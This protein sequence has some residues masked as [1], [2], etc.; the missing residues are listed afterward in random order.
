MPETDKMT[1]LSPTEPLF[2]ARI[3]I[4]TKQDYPL[5]KIEKLLRKQYRARTNITSPYTLEARF[6]TRHSPEE[7]R[8]LLNKI[9]EL[10]KNLGDKIT[11][12]CIESY[13]VLKNMPLP[14]KLLEKIIK[15][16]RINEREI[17]LVKS[18]SV[19][20]YIYHN[21]SKRTISIRPLKNLIITNIDLLQL[22]KT[23]YIYCNGELHNIMDI[24]KNF[25]TETS[26][27]L[28]Q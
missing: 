5:T 9:I 17:I 12:F 21:T 3:T 14:Q 6:I 8:K 20:M 23:S 10:W 27:L 28:N 24:M 2:I 26:K 4:E 16:T 1:K 22:P 13:I 11:S 7:I 18:N 15:K 25:I 19:L